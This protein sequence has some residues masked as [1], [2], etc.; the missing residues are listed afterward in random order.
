MFAVITFYFSLVA[1]VFF[2]VF[3]NREKATGKFLFPP[4]F[5]M[6]G[7]AFIKR[8]HDQ[9]KLFISY[10]NKKNAMIILHIFLS[11]LG[12]VLHLSHRKVVEQK[13]KLS[14]E[15]RRRHVL[16]KKGSASLFLRNVSE[17]KDKP[18]STAQ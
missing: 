11:Y 10:L 8:W 15:L 12:R 2:V 9:V 18:N 1:I 14:M 16:E 6:R 13:Q 7:D 4:E 3:K 5:K 17:Y